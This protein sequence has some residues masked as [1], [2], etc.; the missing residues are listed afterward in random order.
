MQVSPGAAMDPLSSGS[1]TVS[2]PTGAFS[3]APQQTPVVSAEPERPAVSGTAQPT[4]SVAPAAPTTAALAA[5]PSAAD[6][7]NRAALIYSQLKQ[8]TAG[9]IDRI[10]S[11]VVYRLP[12]LPA[13]KAMKVCMLCV[14]PLV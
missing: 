13:E 2:L 3:S 14:Y 1:T 8:F 7:H 9:S 11:T 10:I 12:S 5:G 4:A 6:Q